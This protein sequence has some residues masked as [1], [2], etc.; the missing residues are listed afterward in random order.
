M[1]FADMPS[2]LVIAPVL[3]LDAASDARPGTVDVYVMPA[4]DTRCW[5]LGGLEQHK[6]RVRDMFLRFQETQV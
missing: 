4:V 1:A 5:T 6:D 3:Y 2:A